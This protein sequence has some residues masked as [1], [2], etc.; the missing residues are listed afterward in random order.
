VNSQLRETPARNQLTSLFTEAARWQH[1]FLQIFLKQPGVV[2]VRWMVV[3]AG[4][5]RVRSAPAAGLPALAC[6]GGDWS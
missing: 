3:A 1:S 2:R 4:L 5:S 6:W